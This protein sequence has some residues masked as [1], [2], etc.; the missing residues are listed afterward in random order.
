MA[1]LLL[2]CALLGL[3]SILEAAELLERAAS[4]VVP[5]ARRAQ[6]ERERKSRLKEIAKRN[7]MSDVESKLTMSL[8]SSLMTHDAGA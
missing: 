2:D 5:E 3:Q 8:F 4:V 6:G 1:L 7:V